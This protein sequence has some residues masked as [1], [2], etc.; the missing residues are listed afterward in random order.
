[1][2][3]VRKSRLQF[4][5]ANE[6]FTPSGYQKPIELSADPVDGVGLCGTPRGRGSTVSEATSRN[7]QKTRSLS[8]TLSEARNV[9]TGF[10]GL[11]LIGS[12]RSVS[13]R[14]FRQHWRV[15]NSR[16]SIAAWKSFLQC[17]IQSQLSCCRIRTEA[18]RKGEPSGFVRHCFG[19]T[20]CR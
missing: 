1:M 14:L 8:N 11:S 15:G 13:P 5:L 10:T 17:F 3:T 4:G 16:K 7:T 6:R 18:C 9:D 19:S 2:T 12:A 20:A